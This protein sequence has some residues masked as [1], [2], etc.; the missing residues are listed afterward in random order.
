MSLL[1]GPGSA[2][3]EHVYFTKSMVVKRANLDGSEVET[4]NGQIWNTILGM[5]AQNLRIYWAHNASVP[6]GEATRVWRR[7]ALNGTM[8]EDV[9]NWDSF[10]GAVVIDIN[11]E[12]IYWTEPGLDRIRSA[13]LDTGSASTPV[14]NLNEPTGLT[15]DTTE[16]VLYWTEREDPGANTWRIQR[17]DVNG[18]STA[19]VV[20]GLNDA[21]SIVLDESS[22]HLYWLSDGAIRRADVDGTNV[23]EIIDAPNAQFLVLDDINGRLYWDGPSGVARANL[24][25]TGFEVFLAHGAH[26]GPDLRRL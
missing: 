19:T 4:F 21:S 23:Q 22:S 1:L 16:G 7:A 24:D 20:T 2:R 17:A 15:L 18:A 5:D 13:S 26:A 9:A 14:E 6:G 8:I 12:R 11:N 25:G 10:P 3:A